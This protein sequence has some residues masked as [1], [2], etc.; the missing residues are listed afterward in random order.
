MSG[1]Q[2]DGYARA[3]DGESGALVGMAVR[4]D[5]DDTETLIEEHVS[6]LMVQ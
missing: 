2:V 3:F 1:N 4:A 5:S 6:G